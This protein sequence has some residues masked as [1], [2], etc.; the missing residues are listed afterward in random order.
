MV[1][2]A[3][4]IARSEVVPARFHTAVGLVFFEKEGRV[5]DEAFAETADHGGR[6]EDVVERAP[7]ALEAIGAAG[8]VAA[9]C[10]LGNVGE[11]GRFDVSDAAVVGV[12]VEVATDH[13]HGFWLL[14]AKRV[15]G[16]GEAFGHEHAMGL[17]G[18]FAPRAARCMDDEDVERVARSNEAAGEEDVASGVHVLQRLNAQG[19]VAEQSEGERRIE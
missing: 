11:R 12:V 6:C 15:D 8:S 2:E 1:A 5:E 17:R 14:S 13:N 19:T 4:Q 18:M 7:I 3:S 16:L 10:L 9:A